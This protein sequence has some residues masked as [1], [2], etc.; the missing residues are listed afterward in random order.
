MNFSQGAQ[1]TSNMETL[2]FKGNQNALHKLH[3]GGQRLKLR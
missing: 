3:I 2:K 1:L